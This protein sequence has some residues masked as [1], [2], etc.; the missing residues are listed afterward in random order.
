MK[1][2]CWRCKTGSEEPGPETV[3]LPSQL[4][5]GYVQTV[6]WQRNKRLPPLSHNCFDFCYN[7]QNCFLTNNGIHFYTLCANEHLGLKETNNLPKITS[8]TVFSSSS[9]MMLSLRIPLWYGNASEITQLF[10]HTRG[11]PESDGSVPSG[12]SAWLSGQGTF[13]V[14][15]HPRTPTTLE[16]EL[17]LGFR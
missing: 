15:F 2:E 6:S 14:N 10:L 17:V 4:G 5:T 8:R 12:T 7:S 9:D 13:S 3:E 11:M 1:V 16:A